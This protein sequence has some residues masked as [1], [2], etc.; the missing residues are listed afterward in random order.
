MKLRDLAFTQGDDG[1]ARK[2]E[3]LEQRCHIGLVAAQ[4]IQRLGEHN[5]DSAALGIL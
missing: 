4:A 1:C 2:A 3:M 5:V